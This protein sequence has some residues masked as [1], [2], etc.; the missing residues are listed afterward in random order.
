MIG[1]G[2]S[3]RYELYRIDLATAQTTVI[4][5]SLVRPSGLAYTEAPEPSALILGLL[6][7][8]AN[9]HKKPRRQAPRLRCV[10]AYFASCSFFRSATISI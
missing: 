9:A 2:Y 3:G 1:I 8:L 7:V 4:G 5:L 6:A 10:F